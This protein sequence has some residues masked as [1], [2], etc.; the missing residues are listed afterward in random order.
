LRGATVTTA[1]APRRNRT[2]YPFSDAARAETVEAIRKV[3]SKPR[4]G[5]SKGR[6]AQAKAK[7]RKVTERVIRTEAGV[8]VTL[9]CRRG[10]DGPAVLAALREAT[11][12]VEAELAEPRDGQAAA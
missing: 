8:R 1:T 3:A 9:E 2:K 12:K 7:A 11:A 4:A 10:L 5:E 6:G